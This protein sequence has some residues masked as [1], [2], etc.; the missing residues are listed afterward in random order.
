MESGNGI[1]RKG[2]QRYRV[3]QVNA[4]SLSGNK[5]WSSLDLASEWKGVIKDKLGV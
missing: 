5:E 2:T 1:A 3:L 4:R